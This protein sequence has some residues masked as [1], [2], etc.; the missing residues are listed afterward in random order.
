MSL[1]SSQRSL[2]TGQEHSKSMRLSGLT[3]VIASLVLLAMALA[4]WPGSSVK[5]G[6]ASASCYGNTYVS[7]YSRSN[8]TYVRGHYRTC[9]DSIRSNNY[10]FSGN[11]NPNTGRITGGSRNSYSDYSYGS[12]SYGSRGYGSWNYSGYRSIFG[13]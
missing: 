3:T 6:E 7:S 10:S 12:R 4:I 8:G 5:P 11:Y 9:P 2:I 1:G 13:R